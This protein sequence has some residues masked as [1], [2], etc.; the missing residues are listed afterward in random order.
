MSQQRISG[1]EAVERKGW[2]KANKWLVLRRI[3]QLG[4]LG[5]FLLGPLAGIWIVQGTLSASTVFGVL[6]LTDPLILLQSLAAG[7]AVTATAVVGA[8]LVA[9]LYAVIGGRV[10]CS[11]VCPVNVFTDA[12][13]WLHRRLGLKRNVN[14]GRSTRYWLLALLLI[15]AAATGSIVWE[16]V[17][18]VTMLQRGLL[19]GMG[20]GWLLIAAVFALDAF[21][22][23]RGWCGHLCPVGAGYSLL[24]FFSLLR[25]KAVQREH[26]TDCMDCFAVCPEP[27][28]IRPALKGDE[29]S[30]SVIL[31]NNCLNCGR[32]IDICPHNVFCFSGRS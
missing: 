28:V 19:F 12:A 1:R 8:L 7:H 26:C 24:G 16:L 29:Q 15:I 32:C 6:P 27:Q 22:Q 30:S 31:S 25:V 2:L 21:V 4:I 14:L 3:S 20:A 17:N 10:F 9:V 23:Q 5:L 11:W 13:A 18:P